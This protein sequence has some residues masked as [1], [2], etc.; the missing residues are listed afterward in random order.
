MKE[1]TL[2]DILAD[3]DPKAEATETPETDDPE[4]EPEETPEAPETPEEDP[5]PDPE[6]EPAP[7]KEDGLQAAL[8]ESRAETRALKEQMAALQA[9]VAE[10]N[11]PKP[12]PVEPFK[13]PDP[14]ADQEAYDSALLSHL[15]Q[16]ERNLIATFSER[17]AKRAHGA[18][19]VDK[20]FAKAEAAGMIPRFAQSDDPYGDLMDWDKEQ[21]ELE[22]VR[23]AGGIE[24]MKAEIRK[25]LEAEMK[26]NAVADQIAPSAPSLGD[27]T[28]LGRRNTRTQPDVVDESLKDILGNPHDM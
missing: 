15:D 24:A 22:T 26:A 8:T 11:K 5:E 17:T 12:E 10:A 28:D 23:T 18:E 20:A 4:P 13:L 3:E 25:E 14:M 16:R 21:S 27:E 9:Q 7:S 1:E 6:P 2:D 19:A